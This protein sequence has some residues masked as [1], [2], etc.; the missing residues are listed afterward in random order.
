MVVGLAACAYEDEGDPLP[1]AANGSPGP[2]RTLPAK[3][4]DVLAAEA[5]NY[6]ELEQRLA[7]APGSVL[8]ADAG[9]A[10]GPGVGFRKAAT[11]TAAGPYTVTTACVGIPRAQIYLSQGIPG[12]TDYQ[13]FE[14]ECSGTQTQVIQLQKGYIGAQLMGRRDPTAAWTGAVAGIR[15]TVG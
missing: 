5:R 14:V 3:D 13:M 4:P 8:L 9:P 6:A 15:I 12:G 11:V 2:A 7:A 10:D 1:T